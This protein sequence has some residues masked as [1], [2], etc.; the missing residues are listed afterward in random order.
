MNLHLKRGD[1][2]SSLVAQSFDAAWENYSADEN[3]DENDVA[4]TWEELLAT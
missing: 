4:T 3:E 2:D 1:L